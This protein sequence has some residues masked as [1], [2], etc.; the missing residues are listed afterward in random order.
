MLSSTTVFN[1]NNN[2]KCLFLTWF[3]KDHVTLKT[4]AI[5]AENSFATIEI[6][7]SLKNNKIEKSYFKMQ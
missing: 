4:G 6:N 7:Y 2:K 1:I 3:L 5:A